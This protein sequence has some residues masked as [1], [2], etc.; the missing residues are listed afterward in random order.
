MY[1]DKLGLYK[2]TKEELSLIHICFKGAESL[3]FRGQLTL[4]FPV[5][6]LLEIAFN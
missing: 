2:T 5:G 3:G 1:V 4:D 6:T